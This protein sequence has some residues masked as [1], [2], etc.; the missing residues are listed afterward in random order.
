[1]RR[2]I[3]LS[4]L[5]PLLGTVGARAVVTLAGTAVEASTMVKM[6]LAAAN[7]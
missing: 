2:R 7:E 1:M 6:V 5:T 4:Y 3:Q